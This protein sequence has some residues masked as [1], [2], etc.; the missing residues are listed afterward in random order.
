MSSQTRADFFLVPSVQG[1]IFSWIDLRSQLSTANK[2]TL[3][4]NTFHTST[5]SLFVLD[6]HYILRLYTLLFS[7]PTTI[8]S[9]IFSATA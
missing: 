6:T 3:I 5:F 7:F 4:K 9:A 2:T 1:P 8:P